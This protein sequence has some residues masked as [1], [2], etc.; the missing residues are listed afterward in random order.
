M[1]K[2]IMAAAGLLLMSASAQA[3]LVEYDWKVADDGDVTLDTQTSKLW[4]DLDVTVGKSINEVLALTEN[5]AQFAGWRLPTVDEIHMLGS[6]IFQDFNWDPTQVHYGENITDADKL[7]HRTMGPS[8]AHRTY[9]YFASE[10]KSM[11]F[12]SSDS[13][14]W[15]NYSYG[16]HDVARSYDGVYLVSEDTSVS[17]DEADLNAVMGGV[18]DVSA[19]AL[20][21]LMLAGLGLAGRRKRQ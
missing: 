5:D 12:G 4:L 15:Y 10:G 16:D 8:S 19:P 9:G 7:R 17:I 1:K 21:V 11:M 20:G 3:E 13:G 6:S 14:L 2:S 18:S